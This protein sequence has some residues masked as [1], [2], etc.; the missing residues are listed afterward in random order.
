MK[1]LLN[2]IF[3]LLCSLTWAQNQYKFNHFTTD[4]GLPSN[5]IYSITEDKNGKIILG[6]DNGLTFFNGND[7]TTLNVKDGLINPYI[8]AVEIDEKGIIWLLNYNEQVQKYNG[9]KILKTSISSKYYNS[10][11]VTDSTIVL[12]SMQNRQLYKNYSFTEVNK[13]NNHVKVNKNAFLKTK[14]SFPFYV[15]NNQVITIKNDTVKFNNYHFK[16]PKEV[17][18]LHKIVFRKKDVL[19]VDENKLFISTLNGILLNSIPFPQNLSQNPIYKYDFIIDKNENCWLNIQ[20][21]GI[22]ILKDYKWICINDNLGLNTSDNVNF[23][24]CDSKNK[25]WIATNENGLYCIPN[26]LIESIKFKN[27]E[28]YFNGFATSLNNKSLYISSKFT[29]YNYKNQNLKLI[30]KSKKEIKLGNFNAV[31]IIYQSINKIENYNKDKNI[32]LVGGKEIIKKKNNTYY[33]LL[34]NSNI[35]V[36]DIKNTTIKN[37]KSNSNEE[38]KIKNIVYYKNEY[39]FNNSKKINIRSFNDST[40]KIKRELKLNIKGFIQDFIFIKDTLWIAANNSVYKLVNEKIIESVTHVN[41]VKFDNIKKIKVIENDIFL[42][43]GNGLFLISKNGNKVINKYNFLP[44]N[45][46]YNVALFNNELFVATKDG[47]GKINFSLIKN[48][49]QKPIFKII[50]NDLSVTKINVKNNQT[51]VKLNLDIQNFNV[52]KN[53]IIQYKIDASNWITTQNKFI[54]FQSLS[55]GSHTVIVRIRDVNSNWSIIKISIYKMYPFYLKWWF[56]LLILFLFSTLLYSIY[57]HQIKKIKLKKQQEISINNKIVELR[58]SALSAMM[59]PHFIFNSLNAIQYFVNSNQKE[60]SSEHL[61][62][63]SRLV[64]LFLSQ[65]SQPFITLQDEINR[66]KLYLELEQVRFSNFEFTIN[67]SE[68]IDCKNVSIPNM[69]VQP[70]IENAILHGVSHLK[71]NDGKIVINFSLTNATLTI[72]IIDNGYGINSS[73]PQ[74]ASHISKGIS[75]ITERLELLQLSYPDKTFSILQKPHLNDQLRKGHN[76]KITVTILT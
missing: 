25:I 41:F 37:L 67:T 76:V 22:F 66:L 24:Y 32:L 6:T 16:L 62:K 28:N 36:I 71:E 51:I 42:C 55:Y 31:P 17:T 1:T 18:F 44:N 45:E 57:R 75:I 40:I 43:A 73:K 12:Y 26:L 59:N 27:E 52:V 35:R 60:K 39:Y 34:G 65:A 70:F 50:Y 64:R 8:V 10:L 19:L 68:N 13:K 72:E 3:L 15:Q 29:L 5:T 53:Q 47:L 74:D 23:L 4:D 56:L 30:E 49:S 63:L 46:V 9:K 21:K 38:E 61:A 48:K 69:I 20:G 58:Q 7:F 14:F 11:I 2:L 33:L 54:I